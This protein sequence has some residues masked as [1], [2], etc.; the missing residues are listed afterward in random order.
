MPPLNPESANL[1]STRRT[2]LQVAALAPLAAADV[3]DGPT[4]EQFASLSAKLTGFPEHSL[5][6]PFAHALL[7][8]LI[9]Q[10]VDAEDLASLRKAE[11]GGDAG[12][13][14]G[15]AADLA[16]EIVSAWYT[17]VLPTK[18]QPT[19]AKFYDAL[20]WQTL[21]FAA[22]P[23]VCARPGAWAEAPEGGEGHEES[24]LG[25]G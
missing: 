25:K 11:H 12:E 21:D 19:V 6:R 22:A 8:A 7:Q 2:A 20:V 14:S 10:G 24:E 5:D 23:T 18:P 4:V 1:T 16:V 13:R 3:F 17:G 9:A 15:P